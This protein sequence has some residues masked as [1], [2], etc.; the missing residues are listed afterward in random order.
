MDWDLCQEK[1][2]SDFGTRT[3][4]NQLGVGE[5]HLSCQQHFS[6]ERFDQAML[7]K[8]QTQLNVLPSDSTELMMR[9][10]HETGGPDLTLFGPVIIRLLLVRYSIL[11]KRRQP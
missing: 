4:E 8:G 9:I 3:A 10:R 6:Y 1:W 5:H 7:R 11:M 2:G